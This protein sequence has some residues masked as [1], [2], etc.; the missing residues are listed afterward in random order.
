VHGIGSQPQ[1]ETLVRWGDALVE[2]LAAVRRPS[3]GGEAAAAGEPL[4]GVRVEEAKAGSGAVEEPAEATLVLRGPDGGEESWL[5]TEAWWADAFPPPTY[6]E[7]VSWSVRAA[8]WSIALHVAQR[9]WQAARRGGAWWRGWALA[10]AVVEV[11]LALALSPLL[12]ALLAAMLLVGLLPVPQLR[13]LILT[14]QST[15]TATVGDSLA[16][17]GSP[18]RAALVRTRVRQALARLEERCR[19]TVVVAHSQGAAVVL[20]ALGGMDDAAPEEAPAEPPHPPPRLTLL[21]LGAGINKLAALRAARRF[22]E[23]KGGNPVTRALL[24]LAASGAIAG[25][26]VL[27][28]LAGSLDGAALLRSALA[29]AVLLVVLGLLPGLV[30]RVLRRQPP[31]AR[32]SLWLRRGLALG[33][34]VAAVV[35]YQLAQRYAPALWLLSFLAASLGMLVFALWS[36]LRP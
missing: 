21:T 2:V 14:V 23:Q 29:L 9:Y 16:F 24:G 5:L 27:A 17:V 28:F 3:S 26:L 19:R 31:E 1:R 15:L 12:V 11:L 32:R 7:L 30:A 20:E 36:V 4:L 33:V 18:L 35:V 6:A 34:M 25:W 13:A 8:P 10:R 22:D